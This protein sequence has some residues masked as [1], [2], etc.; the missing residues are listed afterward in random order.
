MPGKVKIPKYQ[1]SIK[2]EGQGKVKHKEFIHKTQQRIHK[3]DW[4]TGRLHV[5]IA[6]QQE[7]G[8]TTEEVS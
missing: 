3:I 2:T 8:N 5:F 7:I 6:V 1:K 4:Q